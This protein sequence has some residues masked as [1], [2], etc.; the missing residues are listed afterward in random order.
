M[1]GC[2]TGS[3]ENASLTSVLQEIVAALNERRQCSNLLH[4]RRSFS[5]ETTQRNLY[6]IPIP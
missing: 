2:Y 5:R 3:T 1:A 4:R 6:R